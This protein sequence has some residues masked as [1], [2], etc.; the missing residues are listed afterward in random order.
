MLRFLHLGDPP[1]SLTSLSEFPSAMFFLSYDAYLGYSKAAPV[2]LA[3]LSELYLVRSSK[4]RERG[5]K[6]D[7]YMALLDAARAKELLPTAAHTVW[8]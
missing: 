7:G 1:L 3:W 8:E 4:L 5:W 2:T 6:G